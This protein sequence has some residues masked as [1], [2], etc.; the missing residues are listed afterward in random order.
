MLKKG[1]SRIIGILWILVGFII[2][3]GFSYYLFDSMKTNQTTNSTIYNMT[4]QG[5][6]VFNILGSSMIIPIILFLFIVVMIFFKYIV[7]A[8]GGQY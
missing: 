4:D 3:V 5:E 6:K 1:D 7:K 8:S 2:L